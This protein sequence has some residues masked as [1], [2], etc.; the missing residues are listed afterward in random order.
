MFLRAAT[1]TCASATEA[2]RASTLSALLVRMMGTRAPNTMPALSARLA[3][4][5]VEGRI[6][7]AKQ[8]SREIESLRADGMRHPP[9]LADWGRGLRQ[10]RQ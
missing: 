4:Q 7:R 10:T 1:S 8:R 3:R 6:R 5:A 2:R 9:C